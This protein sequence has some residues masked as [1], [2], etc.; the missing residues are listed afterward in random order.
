[1]ENDK[2]GII[3]TGDRPTGR[4]HLGHYVGSLKNRVEL[5]RSYT[6]YVMV[7][8]VQALTD[9]ADNPEKV[10]SNVLEITMDNL[11]VGVDPALTTFFIQ[12]QIPEIAELTVFF[13]NLV[14]LARLKR[15]PTIR[16]EMQQ[17]GYGED[18]PAGF[19]TY[20]INQAADILVLKADTVPVGEDQL[21]VLEQANEIIEKFNRFYSKVFDPIKPLLSATPRLVGMDGNAKMSKSLGNALYLSDSTSVVEEKVMAMYTDPL[22]VRSEDPGHLEG[23]VVFD[24]LD[25]FD[26]DTAGLAELKAHYQKGGVGDR[27][28]KKRLVGVLETFLTP[29]RKRRSELEKDPRHVAAILE[30]GRKKV[31]VV[32]QETLAEVRKAMKIDY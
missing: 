23:N 30:E 18:V 29:I 10:R 3:L 27:E 19:L 21:P 31:A 11:A 2:K 5:Q 9:N 7:A 17:K 26:T 32:A 24:Y 13:L 25:A 14:T 4:L 8:D 12:S 16:D 15:N 20:P 22:H 6:Q 28:V 1:M